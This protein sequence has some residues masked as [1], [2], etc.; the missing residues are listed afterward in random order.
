MYPES[1]RSGMSTQAPSKQ[2]PMPPRTIMTFL[3]F[4]V[5][6]RVLVHLLKMQKHLLTSLDT[7][8]ESMA[9]GNEAEDLMKQAKEQSLKLIYE[10]NKG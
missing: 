1:E 4:S 6:L 10:V 8:P 5:I 3:V 9:L 2:A 7:T